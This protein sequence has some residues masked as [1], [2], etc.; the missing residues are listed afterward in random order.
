MI[1]VESSPCILL[2]KPFFWKKMGLDSF[3]L[4]DSNEENLRLRKLLFFDNRFFFV[5]I[6]IVFQVSIH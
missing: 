5:P 1:S 3:S 6:I 4:K 2:I